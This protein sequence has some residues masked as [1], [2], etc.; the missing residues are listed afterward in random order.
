MTMPLFDYTGVY[1]A[2]PGTSSCTKEVLRSSNILSLE[3]YID[4]EVAL[5]ASSKFKREGRASFISNDEYKRSR[6]QRSI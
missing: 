3:D 1:I 5:E 4:I 2:S 6:K